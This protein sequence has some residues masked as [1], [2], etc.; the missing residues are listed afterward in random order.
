MKRI[1]RWGIFGGMIV[2]ALISS[3]SAAGA[4]LFS[5]YTDRVLARTEVAGITV[6]NLSLEDANARILEAIDQLEKRPL[7]FKLESTKK[8]LTLGELGITINRQA[9]LAQLISFSQLDFPLRVQTWRDFFRLKSLP[10]VATFDEARVKAAIEEQFGIQNSATDAAL[11]VEKGELIVQP[12]KTGRSFDLESTVEELHSYI[13]GAGDSALTLTFSTSPPRVSTQAAKTAKT[14]IEAALNPLT[15]T[16]AETTY[17]I[18]VADQ[19]NLI[20]YEA[21]EKRLNWKLDE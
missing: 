7:T 16:Y 3:A 11:T 5:I 2:L 8:A 21:A 17:T 4:A 19:Y 13:N 14:Q 20:V 12:A 10:L 18:P 15:L 6:S 1:A 9:T